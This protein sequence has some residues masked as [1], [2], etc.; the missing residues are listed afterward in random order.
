[1]KGHLWLPRPLVFQ[2]SRMHCILCF[3]CY[4]AKDL[5]TLCKK[6][7]QLEMGSI[8]SNGLQIYPPISIDGK[9]PMGGG[10]TRHPVTSNHRTPADGKRYITATMLIQ[11]P[12]DYYDTKA[13]FV[14]VCRGLTGLLT[15]VKVEVGP[16]VTLCQNR[17]SSWSIESRMRLVTAVIPWMDTAEICLGVMRSMLHPLR[18]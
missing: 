14:V 5:T 17:T 11:R 13:Y 4:M 1:M 10:E 18:S 7:Q 8:E 15:Y 3:Q 9:A 2:S 16:Y 6:M 12:L